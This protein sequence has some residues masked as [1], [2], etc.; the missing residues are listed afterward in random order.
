MTIGPLQP[1]PGAEGAFAYKSGF[2]VV[3]CVVAFVS[4]LFA[5]VVLLSSSLVTVPKLTLI[6]TLVD[7]LTWC[8]VE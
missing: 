7:E 5:I 3:S 1:F 4:D 2:S 6:L 8:G